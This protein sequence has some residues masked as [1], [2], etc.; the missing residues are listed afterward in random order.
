[1]GHSFH[2]CL[3]FAALA[4]LAGLGGLAAGVECWHDGGSVS[5]STDRLVASRIV[6]GDEEAFRQVFRTNLD[7]VRA[8]IFRIAGPTQDLDDLVQTTFVEVFRSCGSFRGDCPL[9]AWIRGVA[10]R[11]ALH[12]IRSMRRASRLVLVE[13]PDRPADGPDPHAACVTG[14]RL[15]RLRAALQRLDPEKRAVLVLH[16]VE[17]LG[18]ADIAEA[19]GLSLPATKARLLRGRAELVRL[20]GEDQVLAELLAEGD[21]EG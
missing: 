16:E 19:L 11:V 4:V 12:G 3:S 6:Q 9:G 14:Q 13:Q 8:V 1:M 20:A 15:D 2:R 18:V 10:A 21:H 7:A 5:D 17:G